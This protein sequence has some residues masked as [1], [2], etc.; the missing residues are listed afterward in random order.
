MRFDRTDQNAC[1]LGEALEC[2]HGRVGRKEFCPAGGLRGCSN[3]AMST[4][5]PDAVIR[6]YGRDRPLRHLRPVGH[7]PLGDRAHPRPAGQLGGAAADLRPAAP[8]DP[9]RSRARR[10]TSRRSARA[11]ASIPYNNVCEK[12]VLFTPQ[13]F[14][15]ARSSASSR[16]AS[17]RLHLRRYR[18]PT[19]AP[20]RLVV[21][22]VRG[23]VAPASWRSSRSR[24]CSTVS[25]TIS[26]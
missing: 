23:L 9:P 13:F 22:L 6:S 16:G 18:A 1:D 24:T 8:G 2:R 15:P 25:P 3:D 11:C 12:R 26:A 17:R 20:I 5:I 7:R 14:D 10:S 21:A 4:A 19:S